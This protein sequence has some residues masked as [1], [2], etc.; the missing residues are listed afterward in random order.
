MDAS[1]TRGKVAD[2]KVSVV[3]DTINTDYELDI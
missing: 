1:E 3:A 2:E